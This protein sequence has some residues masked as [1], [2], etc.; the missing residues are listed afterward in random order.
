MFEPQPADEQ[1]GYHGYERQ[2]QPAALLVAGLC[3]LGDVYLAFLHFV[4]LA[5]YLLQGLL[6]GGASPTGGAANG[7]P[8]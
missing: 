5:E 6:V 3:I 2:P 4:D 7:I 8:L 1:F